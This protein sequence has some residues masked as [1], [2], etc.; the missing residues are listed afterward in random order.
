ML[1]KLFKIQNY[2]LFLVNMILYGMAVAITTPF[3][4]LYMTDNHGLTV[5]QF[6][7]FM[8]AGAIG[9]FVVNTIVGRFSDQLSFDR[10]YLLLIAIVM[11]IITFSL[12]LVLNHTVILV[13]GYIIF[14]SL[15]APGLPQLYA[16]ARESVN[17]NN[18]N[19]TRLKIFANTVLRSMFS[20]GFLFGP[21]IG[22]ILIARYDFTG[23]FVGTVVIFMVV[24]VVTLFIK[25]TKVDRE[26]SISQIDEKSAPSLISAPVLILPFIAIILLYVGQWGYLLNMPLYVTEVLGEDRGKVGVLASLCAGLEVPFMIGIGWIASKFET[27]H[28]LMFAGVLGGLFFMSIGLFQSFTVILVGQ[29]VLAFFLA[30]LLGLGISY[31]Q[32]LL[33]DFPGYASTL[34]ANGMVIGQLLGNLLGGLISDMFSVNTAFLFSSG[35]MFTSVLLFA[36]TKSQLRVGEI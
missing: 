10:K 9:S 33:P 18:S 25:P 11:E 12:F 29:V 30:I 28:L 5:T 7:I 23:L 36:F 20:F 19:D 35:L 34:F 24:F 4:V 21:L 2:K 15:G 26:V 32:D 27:K 6:G 1:K 13:I 8:A 31:F 22:S 16:S 17:K 14:F 3:L